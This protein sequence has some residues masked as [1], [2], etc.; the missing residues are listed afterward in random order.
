VPSM[1]SDLPMRPSPVMPSFASLRDPGR[2]SAMDAL[3][4][5]HAPPVPAAVPTPVAAPAPP[6]A[7]RP[8]EWSDL[9]HLAAH[10]AR[11]S[12]QVPVRGLRRL[13]GG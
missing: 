8:P 4:P 1:D 11:W 12:L 2:R 10:V 13:L 5:M 6:P 7:V 9:L 3:F